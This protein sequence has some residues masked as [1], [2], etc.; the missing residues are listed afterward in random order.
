MR[1]IKTFE[2]INEP[3]FKI[4]DTVKCIDNSGSNY[5]QDNKLYII[6]GFKIEFDDCILY[7]I[8]GAPTN[9]FYFEDRFIIATEADIASNKYNL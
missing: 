6:L 5:L 2:S 7:K 3:K 8:E 1:Y 9:A 4:G